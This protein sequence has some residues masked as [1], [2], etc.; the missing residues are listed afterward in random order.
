MLHAHNINA[1]VA[2]HASSKLDGNLK[3]DSDE[4]C[5]LYYVSG[6]NDEY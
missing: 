6:V 3:K 1:A 5:P 4:K 2:F